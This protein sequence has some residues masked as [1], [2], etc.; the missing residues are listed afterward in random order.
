MYF[1][2]LKTLMH[3]GNLLAKVSIG[4]L[5]SSENKSTVY[6]KPF[7]RFLESI[8]DPPQMAH[9]TGFLPETCQYRRKLAG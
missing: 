4:Y 7:A 5:G 2:W 8:G 6:S 9:W 3:V 1:K